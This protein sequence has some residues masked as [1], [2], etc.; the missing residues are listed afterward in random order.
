MF[1]NAYVLLILTTL[2]WGGN[3]I[4]GKLAVGHISPM[5]LTTIRWAIAVVILLAIGLPQFRRDWPLVKRNLLFLF[6]LGAAGF[7]LFNPAL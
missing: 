3:T 2:F 5:I 4:A 6:A 1:R 7:P